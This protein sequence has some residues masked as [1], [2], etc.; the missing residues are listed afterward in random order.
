M[1]PIHLAVM[2]VS[3]TLHSNG[4]CIDPRIGEKQK[5]VARLG[6]PILEVRDPA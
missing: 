1:R 6:F 2:Q 5:S 3:H 4:K